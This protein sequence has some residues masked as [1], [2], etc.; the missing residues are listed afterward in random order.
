MIQ[1]KRS[2][3]TLAYLLLLGFVIRL[4]VFFYAKNYNGDAVLRTL[5]GERWLQDPTF[6]THATHSTWVFAPLHF[7]LI[8]LA[9]SIWDNLLHSP[10]L[11]S[12]VLGSLAII[13][14]YKLTAELFSRKAAGYATLAFCFYTLHVRFS[15]VTTS[16]ATYSFL[17]LF[18]LL[19]F[20]RFFS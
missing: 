13:P 18:S 17:A 14:F 20:F 10:R 12:L 8:G 11:V 4:I 9:L 1:M 7:Y 3:K 5:L 19:F 2:D 16:E 6:V 15:A